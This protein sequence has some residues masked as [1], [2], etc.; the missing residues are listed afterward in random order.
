MKIE[1]ITVIGAGNMGGAIVNGL[2]KSGYIAAT[3]ISIADPREEILKD[4]SEKGV[5]TFQNNKDAVKNTDLVLLAVKPYFVEEVIKEI[6]PALSGNEIITCIA[7]GINITQLNVWLGFEKKIVRGMPNTAISLQE[8]MTCLAGNE[9][10]AKDIQAVKEMFDQLGQTLIINENMM[11]AA[12]V[13][14]SCGTAYALRYARA[15]M[16]AG[17][18]MGFKAD[19]AQFMAAQ[20]IKGAMQITLD[21][22]KHPETEID[23]VC[24]P[25]G[26]TITGL[27][28]MEH[29]GFS[30]SVI[31]GMME[32]FNRM[33]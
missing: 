3:S 28:E 26:I 2:L 1:K 13:L 5:K 19:V 22:S 15:A 18:E 7:A 20:T 25:A 24:T 23:K 27:N 12:T 17:I 10:V 8:S 32:A 30:S 33:Q 4:F 14:A 11:E 9:A 21:T 6:N 16:L 29:N 31:Q